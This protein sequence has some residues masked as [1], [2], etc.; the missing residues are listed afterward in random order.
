MKDTWTERNKGRP[1]MANRRMKKLKKSKP[2]EVT[3][4]SYM[5]GEVPI[6]SSCGCD[7]A[8]GRSSLCGNCYETRMMANYLDEEKDLEDG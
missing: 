7:V 2:P 6:C 1:T 3:P 4:E 8:Y 5:S